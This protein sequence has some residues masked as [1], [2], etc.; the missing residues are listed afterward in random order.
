MKTSLYRYFGHENELL[1]VG[2]S[3]H[4]CARMGQ[5]AQSRD[6]SQVRYVELEWFK[7]RGEAAAAEAIAI[8]RERP[9]WNIALVPA[10]RQSVHPMHNLNNA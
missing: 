9:K 2:V 3:H 6:M 10:P 5:H 7:S 8:K 1:Y 4:P